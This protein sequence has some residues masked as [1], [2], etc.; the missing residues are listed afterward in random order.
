MADGSKRLPAA[1]GNC[2]IASAA[3]PAR[4]GEQ[5]GADWFILKHDFFIG[6]ACSVTGK[7]LKKRPKPKPGTRMR[8]DT[9]AYPLVVH[10]R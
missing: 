7:H 9:G 4:A 3:D 1:R 8:V 10:Q 5:F 2:C 6:M